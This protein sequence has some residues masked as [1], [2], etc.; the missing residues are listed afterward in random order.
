MLQLAKGDTTALLDHNRLASLANETFSVFF[1]HF[2]S[3]NVSATL[4]GQAFQ[5]IGEKLPWGL[6]PAVYYE[7]SSMGPLPPDQ[8]G[9]FATENQ[10][11]P[12]ERQVTAT[13]SVPI[14]QLVMSPI[15]VYLCISILALLCVTTAII[16]TTN[17]PQLKALP[18]DVDTLA[19]TIAFVY[20]SEKLLRWVQDLPSLKPS[21]LQSK[22]TKQ[23]MARLGS[24]RDSEGK[25]RWGIELVETATSHGDTESGSVRER[26]HMPAHQALEERSIYRR[27]FKGNNSVDWFPRD[28]QQEDGNIELR[29]MRRLLIAEVDHGCGVSGSDVESIGRASRQS[30]ETFLQVPN[31]MPSD[32]HL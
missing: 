26:S 19:S 18:R 28:E 31:T 11:V 3:S 14:E 2:A 6:G 12:L 13:I 17:R 22:H 25:E 21:S 9:A 4:G 20:G 1:K 30:R 5:P 32:V 7:G 8:Q 16:Y 10:T 15:A 27:P 24:F 23:M 29:E